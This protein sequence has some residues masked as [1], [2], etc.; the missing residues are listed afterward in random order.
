MKALVFSEEIVKNYLVKAH[1]VLFALI[2]F[3][4]TPATAQRK[5]SLL[6]TLKTKHVWYASQL[7]PGSGQVI[8]RQYW[9]VPIVWGGMGS[10]VYLG[11]NA[12]SEYKRMQREFNPVFY[13]PEEIPFIHERWE[14]KRRERDAY[15]AGAAL[16]YVASISDALLVHTKG[17][18]SP[19]VATVFSTLVPGMGQAYNQK[20]WKI[21]VVWGGI[22]TLYFLVE[23]NNRK[24][25]RV[26]N[27][28]IYRTDDDPT[29]ID[30]FPRLRADDLLY[31]REMYL[32][33]R[34]LASIS[35][36]LFYI[37]NIIDANVDAHLMDWDI[38]DNLALKFEPLFSGDVLAR[39]RGTNPT[40]GF[41][42]R[43]NF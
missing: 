29:T 15:Y 17:K 32:R 20:Y 25:V 24:Y 23:Q 3:M 43:L 22:A 21:P 10:M 14:L 35:L 39:A 28:Y 6:D 1:S 42:C 2:F 26:R 31:Y 7:L 30:E 38:S 33:D 11:Y 19:M 5:A 36:F 4:A 12:N 34:D 41:S 8:N 18:K 37:A 9:K 40:I 13:G 16:F 27:A